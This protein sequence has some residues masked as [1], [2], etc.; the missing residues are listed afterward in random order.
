MMNFNEINHVTSVTSS[1]HI[2]VHARAYAHARDVDM[3]DGCHA[4]HGLLGVTA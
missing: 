2:N 1:S 4:C 3:G